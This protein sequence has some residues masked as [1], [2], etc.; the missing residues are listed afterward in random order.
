MGLDRLTGL[1]TFARTASLGSYTAAARDLSVSP[2]TVSK[3][4]QRLE[5]HWN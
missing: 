5:E 2:S 1:I 4:V 3:S